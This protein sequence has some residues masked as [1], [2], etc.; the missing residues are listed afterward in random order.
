[1]ECKKCRKE[2]MESELT[3]GF[4]NECIEKYGNNTTK[5]RNTLNPIADMLKKW[6]ISIIVAGLILGIIIF[7]YSTEIVGALVCVIA[8]L[9]I[10]FLIRA[11][12][13][14]IQLLEDIKNK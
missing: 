9:P 2:C 1:M 12:A 13:E 5:L 8:S 10:A 7:I 3:N 14:I 11:L 6:F 4:C